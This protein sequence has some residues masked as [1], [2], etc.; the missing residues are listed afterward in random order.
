[1]AKKTEDLKI[2]D[3]QLAKIQAFVKQINNMQLTIGQ[4]ETQKQTVMNQL[5]VVQQ[6]LTKFQ[7][8]LKEEY[9]NVSINIET[10]TIKEIEDEPANK[11]D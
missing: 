2:K 11:E 1:M 10:G 5:F 8:E 3:E 9:G 4:V 7:N 6:E